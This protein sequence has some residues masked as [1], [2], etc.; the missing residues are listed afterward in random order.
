MKLVTEATIL[1]HAKKV[2][3]SLGLRFIRLSLRQGVEVGWP[4][5][6]ILGPNRGAMFMETKRPKGEL[7]PIQ[8]E[9]A[10]TICSY[11]HAYCAPDTKD[12]VDKALIGFAEYCLSFGEG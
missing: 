2:S 10:K 9:R 1:A 5:V 6:L 8:R 11:G 4:D 3:K 12:A 7:R